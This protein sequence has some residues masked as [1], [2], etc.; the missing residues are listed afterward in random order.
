M[1][2]A[3]LAVVVLSK[4]YRSAL[5][6]PGLGLVGN[7]CS[8]VEV[9]RGIRRN[10]SPLTA[11]ERGA[12]REAIRGTTHE[13][14]LLLLMGAGMRPSEALALGWEAVDL[15]TAVLRVERTADNRGAFHPPK[16]EKGRRP[17][18]L[19]GEV[20]RVLRELH[21]RQG[22]P[23]RGLVFSC[24]SGRPL[25]ASMLLRNHFRPALERAQVERTAEMRLYDLRYGYATAALEAGADVRTTA[26]LMGHVD[27]R[28]TM[29]V[30][31]HVS[32][33]RKREA[34]DRI[35]SHLFGA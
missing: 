7:P 19:P 18:P 9:G 11:T 27:T 10:M 14:L 29:E 15:G 25:N 32:S 13:T 20:V 2:T 16:T 24:R 5:K 30:Y 12:F 8:G 21:L 6:D 33:E 26:D 4:L 31:Q 34:V 22:R 17:V 35:S 23:E 1:R 28:L 3:Q